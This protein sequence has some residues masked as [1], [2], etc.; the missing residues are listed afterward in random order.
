[1]LWICS[2]RYCKRSKNSGALIEL[3]IICRPQYNLYNQKLEM[4]NPS[5]LFERRLVVD[6]AVFN[7]CNVFPNQ[8]ISVRYVPKFIKELKNILT[9]F[10]FYLFNLDVFLFSNITLCLEYW[11]FAKFERFFC[12]CHVTELKA[13][14]LKILS[15]MCYI[16]RREQG[17]S[18][19]RIC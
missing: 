7:T 3:L 13:E 6:I 8:E 9:I 5:N 4:M 10:I 2:T 12:F 16:L 11:V 15:K 17:R 18:I 19:L 1:M 14:K